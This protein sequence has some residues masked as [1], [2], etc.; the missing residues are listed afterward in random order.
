MNSEPEPKS[1]GKTTELLE[2]LRLVFTGRG[3][4]LDAILPALLFVIINA[5]WGFT[6][7]L[8]VS[9][10]VA[11][12]FALYRMIKRQSLL[13]VL[14]GLAGAA[15]TVFLS[16]TNGLGGYILSDV[17]TGLLTIGTALLSVLLRRP[18]VAWTSYLV[19]RWPREWYWHPRVRPAYSEVTLAWAVFFAA[20]LGLQ[21]ALAQS[22][23]AVLLS[24]AKLLGGW[25]ATILLLIGS[26]L[27]GL[28]RLRRLAGPSV[29]EYITKIA[30]PWKSQTRGF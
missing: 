22:E 12:A 7:A 9:L 11:V 29:E 14:L 27:Y 17:V 19:R 24:A 13:Y 6:N 20:R 2:E 25:P 26:Y 23:N 4:I 30:P 10:A 5:A 15:L 28:W 18:M 16:L 8:W 21:L 3:S 1:P